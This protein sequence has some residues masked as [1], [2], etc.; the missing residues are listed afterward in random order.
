MAGTLI[1]S[2]QLG[3]R[4]PTINMLNRVK[5]GKGKKID[6]MKG[7]LQVKEEKDDQ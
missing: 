1:V 6:K 5:K 2:V 4:V 7:N 3:D